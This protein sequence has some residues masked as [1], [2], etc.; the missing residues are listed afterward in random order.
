MRLFIIELNN[1]EKALELAIDFKQ[2]LQSD[3]FMKQPFYSGVS[4]FEINDD[5]KIK[6]FIDLEASLIE[7]PRVLFLILLRLKLPKKEYSGKIKLYK[8][9][10]V[11]NYLVEEWHKKK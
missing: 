10:E 11:I 2:N 9:K 4:C 3:S 6:I 8:Q 1:C 5:N 7:V